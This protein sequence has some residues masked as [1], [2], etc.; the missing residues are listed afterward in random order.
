[1]SITNNPRR[2]TR[3]NK[4]IEARDQMRVAAELRHAGILF[5]AQSNG[6]ALGPKVARDAVAA[7]LQRGCPDMLI[8]TR[9]PNKPDQ[10][11]VALEMKVEAKK[12]K[13]ARARRWS[14]A[15]AHQREFLAAMEALGWV[16][17]V[18]Y[19]WRDALEQLYQLG[20][21]VRPDA[22]FNWRKTP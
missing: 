18:A 1:M 13:T 21:D 8:F 16:S 15:E 22:G 11:G 2:A 7:G 9:P 4:Q 19:G 3:P 20:Y 12:P 14:G 6:L 5:N 10:V 17:I